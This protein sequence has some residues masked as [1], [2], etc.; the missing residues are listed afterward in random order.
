M[1]RGAGSPQRTAIGMKMS[2]VLGVAGITALCALLVAQVAKSQGLGID[3]TPA[4]FEVAI[5]PG[6]PAYSIP[7]TI[8]NSSPATVHILA[9]SVDFGLQSNGHYEFTAVGSRPYSLMRWSSINPR[10]FDLPADS[11]QQVRLT[12]TV[13]KR[14]E[15]SGEYAGVV[16]FQTRPTRKANTVA[17]S[18]RVATK[19]YATI[20][21]TVKRDGAIKKMS[22]VSASGGQSYH[23]VFQNLGNT[24][25]YLNGQIQVRRGESVVQTIAMEK[26]MLVERGGERLIE[27][28]GT[29]LPP[30]KYQVVAI[31][32]YGG[33][34]QTGGQIDYDKK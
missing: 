13:P 4:K 14:S 31:I 12:L 1:L 17:L 11:S 26:Q 24:H 32:D 6:T 25:L 9:S 33:K 34:T 8:R 23:V 30:G 28:S 19:I 5:P 21:G 18:V 29:A 3:V 7:I 16:F 20:P 15:L 27:V 22:V 10:E 2:R